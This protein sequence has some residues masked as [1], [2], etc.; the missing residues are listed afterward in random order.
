MTT[1]PVGSLPNGVSVTADGARVYV[2]NS[3]G[4]T[5]S[6]IDTAINTVVGSV[7]V[8]ATPQAFGQFI[9]PVPSAPV[10]TMGEWA[11]ILFGLALVGGAAVIIQ[12]R[13]LAA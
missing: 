1:V 12:R 2:A 9:G 4:N 6:I 8:G 7:V 3:G 13:R 5:V 10:P 11:M